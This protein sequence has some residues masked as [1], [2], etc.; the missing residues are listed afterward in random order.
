MAT[1]SASGHLRLPLVCIHKNAKP[2]CFS[3]VNMSALPVHYYNQKIAWMDKAIFSD[4]FHKDFVPSVK[5]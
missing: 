3:G 2:C 4:W 1:A 5:L